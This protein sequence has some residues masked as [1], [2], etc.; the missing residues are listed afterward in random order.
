MF[1]KMTTF[2]NVRAMPSRTMR[3]GGV[4]VRS[5]PSNTMRP[6]FGR[7]SRVIK[8]NS[9]VLPAPFGP[10]RPP[11]SPGLELQSETSASA[12]TPPNRRVTFSTARSAI[13]FAG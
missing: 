1:W 13:G 3:C 12:T 11:M 2:W 5:L 7:Y 10:I 4:R 9:V 6:S 8:L